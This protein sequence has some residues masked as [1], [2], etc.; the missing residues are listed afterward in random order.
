MNFQNYSKKSKKNA[1]NDDFFQEKEGNWPGYLHTRV[2]EDLSSVGRDQFDAIDDLQ[3]PELAWQVQGLSVM[4]FFSPIKTDMRNL[5]QYVCV[6]MWASSTDL[7]R[8][9][10]LQM[11]HVR[12]KK[13]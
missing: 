7:Y 2:W 10:L 8:R 12:S 11:M 4:I 13:K 9:W 3:T 5:I 1:K 6:L